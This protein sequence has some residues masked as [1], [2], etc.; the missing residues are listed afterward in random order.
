MSEP[1]PFEE[2]SERLYAALRE[3]DV[4]RV[5]QLVNSLH[6]AEIGT[7]LESLPHD[8]R[9]LVWEQVHEAMVGKVLTHLHETVR[10][11]LIRDMETAELIAATEDL[12]PDDLADLIPELPDA[13]IAQLLST[14]DAQER[15]RLEA[16]LP[17]PE[18][19][20]GGLMNVDTV[21][22][23]AGLTLEVV[24]RYLRLLGRLPETTDSLMVVNR[25]GRLLGVLPL[26]QVLTRDSNLTVA[27]VM[28]HD[29]EGI[30]ADTPAPEVAKRFEQRDL[31][32]AP[33][34]DA[35]GRLLGRI[36]I[37][38]VVDVIRDEGESSLMRMAGLDEQE[39]MFA[40]VGQSVRRRAVWLAV[41]LV[42]AFTVASVIGLFDTTI[43]KLV[44]L[45]V[46]MPVVASMG[47]VAGNQTLTLV[48]RGIALGQVGISNAPRLVLKELGVGFVNGLV[49]AL[50]V[51]ILA[52]LWFKSISLG[53]V[54]GGAIVV[55]LLVAAFSGATVPLALRRLGID[56]ALAGSVVLTTVTDVVGFFVFL[57]LAAMF[58]V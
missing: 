46:L 22:V 18:D 43:E 6:P 11:G 32:T 13:V 38:D 10:A 8:E 4:S 7:L 42:A 35:H 25:A 30:P 21:T 12:D 24:L 9:L 28:R 57:G 14:M 56:P 36:T 40:P 16:V 17:Y 20:A 2:V 26:S 1:D 45:A 58:L 39:D 34:V 37:D 5:Q 29:V 51:A 31:V 19:T 27:E 23:R 49:W 48:I 47:G 33:V 55:N 44:A 54:I 41:N 52:G 50:I 53:A 15:A 3:D